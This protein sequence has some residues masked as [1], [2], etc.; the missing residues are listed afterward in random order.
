[1]FPNK[2]WFLKKMILREDPKYHIDYL[3]PCPKRGLDVV[4][5]N[6]AIPKRKMKC[7]HSKCWVRYLSSLW[8]E[9]G[10]LSTWESNWQSTE[11]WGVGGEMLRS[12]NILAVSSTDPTCIT[13]WFCWAVS[14]GHEP[15]SQEHS[16][17]Q[18]SAKPHLVILLGGWE[19]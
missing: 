12:G 3:V 13:R 6:S 11:C 19:Y 16:P 5:L 17:H 18:Q 8:R 7:C 10:E 15:L 9:W 2:I 14:P 1:M 4:T